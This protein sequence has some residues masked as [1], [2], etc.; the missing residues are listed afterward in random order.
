MNTTGC[1]SI[2]SVTTAMHR[3]GRLLATSGSAKLLVFSSNFHRSRIG[4]HPRCAGS[5]LRQPSAE[6]QEQVLL[7]RVPSVRPAGDE[8][9]HSAATAVFNLTGSSASGCNTRESREEEASERCASG[10]AQP[11]VQWT[12]ELDCGDHCGRLARGEPCLQ[13]TALLQSLCVHACV[14]PCVSMCVSVCVHVCV[15]VCVCVCSCVSMCLR[16][17]ACVPPL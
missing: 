16:G 2:Y 6:L 5:G 10:G 11:D 1:G 17:H 8:D 7:R 12:A 14:C 13:P 9:L 15:R 4:W 3:V